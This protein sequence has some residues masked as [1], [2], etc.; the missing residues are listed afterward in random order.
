[1]AYSRLKMRM[2]HFTKD[3]VLVIHALDISVSDNLQRL[4]ALAG[5]LEKHNF[6]VCL[7]VWRQSDDL[8]RNS[9]FY[10]YTAN[11]ALSKRVIVVLSPELTK[12]SCNIDSVLGKVWSAV[13]TVMSSNET[14]C[15]FYPVHLR[16]EDTEQRLPVFG[17]TIY[18]M[19]DST[20]CSKLV[21]HMTGQPIDLP[22]PGQV[23]R[24]G[25]K[26][27]NIVFSC[28]M[29]CFIVSHIS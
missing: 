17:G 12:A 8:S 13:C 26:Q 20:D 18:N 28:F 10:W 29:Q 22:P 25:E 7:D 14:N 2:M 27:G 16:P 19:A 5:D 3:N 9:L 24:L 23:T 11:I 15:K 4:C 1:M 21:R 6:A